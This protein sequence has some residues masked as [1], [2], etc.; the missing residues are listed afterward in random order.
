MNF[1]EQFLTIG[2]LLLTVYTII[3]IILLLETIWKRRDKLYKTKYEDFIRQKNR[4]L[5]EIKRG[6]KN[7]PK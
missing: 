6:R 3:T 4:V 5:N 1:L 2:T 7:A